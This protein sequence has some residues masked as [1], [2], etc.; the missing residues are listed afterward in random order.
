METVTDFSYLGDGIYSGGGCVAA[1]TSRN[2]LGWV[3][4]RECQEILCRKQ[5]PLKI[6]GSVYNRCVRS[7]MLYE[8]ETGPNEIG[9]SQRTEG[10]MMRN[11]CGVKL[12]DK[13]SKNA[14]VGLELN[15]RSA[16]KS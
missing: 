10:A 14:D 5:L 11:M 9:I 13:K 1:V 2:R 15:N 8:N 12:M 4:F 7:A 6:R 3:K 16:G